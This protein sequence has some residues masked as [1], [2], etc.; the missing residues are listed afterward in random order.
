MKPTNDNGFRPGIL[1]NLKYD[2]PA[3]LVVFLVAL[4]LCLGIALASGAPLFSGVIAGIVGGVVI[5]LLS[6]SEVS[7]SGPAAGLAVIVAAAI[8]K[9]GSFEVFL[10]AVA[11]A[12]LIQIAFGFLRA[13]V[14][15]DYVPNA[16]IKGMLAAIG[17]VIIL[18]QIPHALGRD[19]DYEGDSSFFQ[20]LNHENTV[21]AIIKS[22][23]SANGEAVIIAAI[24][25]AILIAW[26]LPALKKHA[27]FKFV[28]AP[29]VVVLLGVALNES[30]K[31]LFT[32]FH[33][34]AADGHLVSLPVAENWTGFF[35]QFTLP[36]FSAFANKQVYITALTIAIVGSIESLLS[37]EAADRLDPFQRISSTNREL[38]AQGVGNFLSGMLGGLPVTSV[39]VRTS[40]NIYAGARTRTSAFTHGL[41]LLAAALLIPQLLNRIPLASLAA[42]LIVIGYKLAKVQLFREMYRSGKTQFLPFIVTVTGI[43]FTDLLMGVL[44]GLAF[45]V[46][47]VIR[48]NHHAAVTVVRQENNYLLRFNKDLTFVNKAELKEKLL[49]L[50]DGANVIID[51]TKSTIIDKD[52]YDV[53]TDFRHSAEFRGI[54][55][56]LKHFYSKAHRVSRLASGGEGERENYGVLQKAAAS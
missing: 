25:L 15:G 22:V 30:F 55:V 39:V 6:G 20:F 48:A 26:D 46:F 41:L 47:F 19:T 11:L 3:G 10:A 2:L 42:I 36:D 17:I 32:D 44:I 23:F 9:L 7:V 38:K 33:L 43:V 34:K 51:A 49:A 16:V 8:Q 52:I 5:S 18:K 13:G 40:A 50:P 21:T 45:G 4:P 28:P 31:L 29:L 56:E 24:S 27:F 14:I 1:N 37:I 35:G 12:G 53:V 54:H